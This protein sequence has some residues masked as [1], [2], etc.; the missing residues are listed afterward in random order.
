MWK[1]IKN[2]ENYSIS[3]E[4]KVK[5]LTT[6]KILKPDC[7]KGYTRYRLC[8]N[9]KAKG[10][11]GHRLVAEAFIANNKGSTQINHKDG[12]KGNNNVDNLEWATPKENIAHAVINN[13][14]DQS[15]VMAIS[16][17]GNEL[18]KFKSIREA[19]RLTGISNQAICLCLQ[20]DRDTASGYY[21]HYLPRANGKIPPL[22]MRRQLQRIIKN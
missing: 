12:D 4:G 15:P 10:F 19:E 18:L 22:A 1:K 9:G 16:V 13:L 2:Y 8:K 11:F 3:S 14:I 21:W 6:G 5:N 17:D 7:I 20:K